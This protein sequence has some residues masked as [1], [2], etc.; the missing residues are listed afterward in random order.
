M[1]YLV[2]DFVNDSAFGF[3]I[4]IVVGSMLIGS[5]VSLLLDRPV[6]LEPTIK[7]NILSTGYN[8]M[9]ATTFTISE[10]VTTDVFLQEN[11]YTKDETSSTTQYLVL[12]MSMYRNMFMYMH[13]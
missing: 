1:I 5:A 2:V 11:T 4:E 13:M 8:N 12:Y 7:Y 10:P 9:P 6:S 3:V